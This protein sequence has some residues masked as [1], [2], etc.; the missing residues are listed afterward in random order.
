MREMCCDELAHVAVG[1]RV[2]YAKALA[3]LAHQQSSSVESLLAAG[4]GGKKMV[5]LDRICNVLG[6][7]PARHGRLYGP[8]CALVGAAL[9]SLAWIAVFGLPAQLQSQTSNAGEEGIVSKSE[10]SGSSETAKTPLLPDSIEQSTPLDEVTQASELPK[11]EGLKFTSYWDLSLDEAIKTSKANA[12]A[13]RSMSGHQVSPA[14]NNGSQSVL[15]RTAT[16]I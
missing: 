9:A 11:P 2:V 15:S 8:S 1:N 14:G 12:K 4:I 13:M 16:S 7:M 3:Y 10:L 6:K 5:L